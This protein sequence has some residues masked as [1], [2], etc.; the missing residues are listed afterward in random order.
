MWEAELIDPRA[1]FVVSHVQGQR[2]EGLLSCLLKDGAKRL[3]NRQRLVLLT[4]GEASYAHLFP[5]IFGQPYRPSRNGSRGRFP[6]LRYR[7]PRT[8]AHVQIVK[9]PHRSLRLA[10]AQPQ[11]KKSSNPKRHLKTSPP[12]QRF[13]VLEPF[14]RTTDR[15]CHLWSDVVASLCL[16]DYSIY[17]TLVLAH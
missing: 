8:L 17:S 11:G 10:L 9:R 7:I 13:K 2:D 14:T 15:Y 1:K 4:D 16:T 6:N 5:E 12:E 3:A